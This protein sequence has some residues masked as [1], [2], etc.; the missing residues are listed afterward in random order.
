MID[1]AWQREDL[2]YLNSIDIQN[3]NLL[4]NVAERGHEKLY[5]S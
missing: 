3:F 2:E 5:P 4:S 1:V